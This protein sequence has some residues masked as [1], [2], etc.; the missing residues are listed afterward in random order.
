MT[1]PCCVGFIHRGDTALRDRGLLVVS[2]DS[3]RVHL[4]YYDGIRY[5]GTILIGVLGT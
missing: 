5:Q 3:Q 1:Q 4:H 2:A